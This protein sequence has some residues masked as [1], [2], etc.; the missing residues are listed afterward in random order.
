MGILRKL[1][2]SGEIFIS[3]GKKDEFID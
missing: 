2:E 3:R 1:E